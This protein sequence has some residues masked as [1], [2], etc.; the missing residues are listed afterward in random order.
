MS[1]IRFYSHHDFYIRKDA[2]IGIRSEGIPYT[3]GKKTYFL[4]LQNQKEIEVEECYIRDVFS[5]LEIKE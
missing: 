3:L 2:I 1:W 4:M 5:Q